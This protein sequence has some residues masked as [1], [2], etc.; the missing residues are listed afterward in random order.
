MSNDISLTIRLPLDLDAKLS[1]VSDFLGITKSNL[2][3]ESIHRCLDKEHNYIEYDFDN[4]EKH[5]IALN[6]NQNT[7]KIL[8]MFVKDNTVSM[9]SAIIFSVSQ[10]VEHYTK[11]MKQLNS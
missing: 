1:D 2:I 8:E 4:S 6:L 5:R 7:Y 9:N 11:L 10:S 3:R